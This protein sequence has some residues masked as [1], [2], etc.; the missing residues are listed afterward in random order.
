MLL[1][2]TCQWA[3]SIKNTIYLGIQ[4][5]ILMGIKEQ[6]FVIVCNISGAVITEWKLRNGKIKENRDLAT[7][8]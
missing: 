6:G 1:K 8:T 2:Q 5:Y 4:R 3:W 7:F